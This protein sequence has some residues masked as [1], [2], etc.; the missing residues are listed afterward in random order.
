MSPTATLLAAALLAAPALAEPDAGIINL[1]VGQQRVIRVANVARVAIGEPEVADVKQVGG[2]ELLITGVGEGRTSLLVWRTGEARLSYSVVV[3][4]QDPKELAGEVRALLGEREGVE[5]RMVGDH[6]FLEGETVTTDDWDRVQEIVQL[7]PS[8]K[9]FVRQS[10]NARVLAAEAL[11]RAYQKSGF[12]GVQARVV[13]STLML[14][15]SV[16]SKDDLK[17]LDAVTRALGEKADNLVT[18]GNRMVMVDVEFVE[19]ATGANKLVG[20]KPPS[21]IVSTGPGATATVSVLQPI[22]GL[23]NGQTQKTASVAL[24]ASAASD[25]SVGARFDEGYV[26]VLS[27]PRLVCRSG[28]KAEF[29]AGGEIPLLTATQNQFAVEFKKFGIVLNVTPTADR[30]GN[31]GTDIHAEVSDVDRSIS[32][33]ANGFEVP[34]F[35]LREVKTSVTVHEGETIVLSG[36]Y[37]YSEDKEVAKMPLLG[38][39]P[40]LGELFKSRN[41]IDHK[42][43][44]AILVTPHLISAESEKVK[45]II[46]DAHKSYEKAADSVSFSVFD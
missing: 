2:G 26:R 12:G 36:L 22:A 44:L 41:F 18:V 29:V 15:G 11:N 13:G 43:E 40:I 19:V 24:N 1:G 14:E 42:T 17:A 25:F 34:G 7:Y 3:R 30:A 32:V 38:H 20:L 21:T 35:R 23:D 37:N 45:K 28:E 39:I 4:K 46:D 33:R 31:I 10:G 9:S 16:E 5:V 27:R 6:I 8:V